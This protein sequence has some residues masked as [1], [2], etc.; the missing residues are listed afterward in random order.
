M[1]WTM[2][3]LVSILVVLF[4]GA[5]LGL[6]SARAVLERGLS[7]TLV[8]VGSWVVRG[9]A[10]LASADPYARA[11][12]AR[13]G[14]IPLASGEGVVLQARRASDGTELTARCVYTVSGAT[15]AARFWTLGLFGR[16]GRPV[17]NP[18]GRESFGSMELTR[19]AAGDFTIVVAA[20]AQPGDW[21]PAPPSGAFTLLLRLYDTPI[22]A[23]SALTPAQVPTITRRAC[24]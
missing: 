12:A 9:G 18:A 13:S 17:A 7:T 8:T 5:A 19:D 15:P 1:A 2:S 24:G 10:D 14:T 6:A 11:E 3:R 20:T 16:D 21:L 22:G 23:S 4:G